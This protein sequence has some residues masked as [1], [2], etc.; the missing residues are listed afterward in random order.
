MGNKNTGLKPFDGATH[1]KPASNLCKDG[2]ASLMRRLGIE[3]QVDTQT[4]RDSA[5]EVRGICPDKG[6]SVAVKKHGRTHG[7][8]V[9]ARKVEPHPQTAA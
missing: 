1:V 6:I 9:A 3:G 4:F 8:W 7:V 2:L 5:F